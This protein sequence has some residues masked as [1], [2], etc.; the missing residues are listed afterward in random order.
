MRKRIVCVFVKLENGTHKV[1]T[2]HP[3]RTTT[4]ICLLT[5]IGAFIGL[6]LDRQPCVGQ[7]QQPEE[8]RPKEQRPNEEELRFFERKVRPILAKRCY[9]CHSENAKTLYAELKVDSRKSLLKGGDTGPAVVPGNPADSLLIQSIQFDEDFDFQM[10]PKGKLPAAEIKI[11]TDWVRQ[12]ASFPESNTVRSKDEKIDF[13]QARNFWSFRPALLQKVPK[14]KNREWPRQRLDSFILSAL[15]SR[16]L[17]PSAAADK[18]IWIRRVTL[19]LIGLPPTPQQIQTFLEDKSP[20]AYEK[21][22]DRLLKSPHY[23]E[24]WARMWLD[25]ARYTD[26]NASWLTTTGQA[27]LYRDW[28]VQAFNDDMPYNEFIRRQLATDYLAQTGP[29][30]LPA[31]GFIG[32]SPN[33]WKELKLPADI[34]KVIVADE[35]EER[36]DTVS[37]TFLGLTVACARCHDHKFDAITMEDYYALAGVFASCRIQERPTINEKDYAP[38]KAAKAEIVKIESQIKSLQK[39]KPL[40]QSEIDA[41]RSKIKQLKAT[42]H[43][44][45]PLAIAIGDES[46]FVEQKNENPQMGTQLVYKKEPRDLHVFVR[47]NPN[48]LGPKV[49]RRF[50]KVLSSK[51]PPEPFQTGSGRLDLAN[52]LTTDASSLTARVIVN[53]L[54]HEHFGQG[55][56]TTPSN[57]GESG[58]RPTH[59]E[60][61]DDMAARLVKNGWSLKSIQ[62]EIVLSATYRQSSRNPASA[63]KDPTN[64]WLSRMPQTRLTVEAWRDSMLAVSGRLNKKL[65]GPSQPLTSLTNNRRTLYGTIHRREMSTML[66]THDF[67]DPTAHSPKRVPTT[68]TL[69]G[70]YALNGPLIL[71]QSAALAQRLLKLPVNSDEKRIEWAY[72]TLFA[73][74]PTSRE[75][76]LALEYVGTPSPAQQIEVWAQYAQVLLASNEFLYVD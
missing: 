75:I 39:Q 38:V 15:E 21:V 58:A 37:R 41:L 64:T 34:I 74:K 6:S 63:Q 36:I 31:L 60:L 17:Q 57:F 32:L 11:L 55:I 45:A 28:V 23:G 4:T 26:R 73:R 51:S 9:S 1:S 70:L 69:Q 71:E 33:Y 66:L 43:F 47:G 67:P 7:T 29:E 20:G 2:P 76:Q 46:L 19:D 27:H 3:T 8:Q 18:A 68:T 40:P 56:V 24:R 50:L 25:L 12:G 53:R 54:W 72:Q 48:R 30:D 49:P 65:G 35:W 14:V 42:K 10:P 22:V 13:D 62:K 44:H 61:L 16:G 5:C 52:A 59:P